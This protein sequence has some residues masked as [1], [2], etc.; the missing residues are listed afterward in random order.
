MKINKKI[1]LSLS[2]GLLFGIVFLSFVSAGCCFDSS[3]GLCTLYADS[4][5]CSTFGGEYF[6]SQTCN[7]N[8]C[9]LGCCQLGQ[10]TEYVTQRQCEIDSSTYGFTTAWSQIGRNECNTLSNTQAEG[11]CV[12]GEYADVCTYT[13]AGECA[14]V[15]HSNTNCIDLGICEATSDN[16]CYK[17]DV[18]Y[19][20]SCGNIANKKEDC[21]YDGGTICTEK[22]YRD[23][24]CRN[25]NCAGGKKN[26][27]SW[28][29]DLFGNG[30]VNV[31][32][33]EQMGWD[34]DRGWSK[35]EPPVGS[36]YFTQTCLDGVII[37]TGCADFRSETC[38]SGENSIGAECKKND[39]NI[40][41]EANSEE[42]DAS[43]GSKVDESA[44]DSEY[45]NIFTTKVEPTAGST[46][47]IAGGEVTVNTGANAGSNEKAVADLHLEMCVPNVKGGLQ[48]YKSATTSSSSSSKESICS[49]GS[50]KAAVTFHR[51]CNIRGT[52]PSLFGATDYCTWYLDTP[53]G[54]YGYAGLL[55]EADKQWG[56]VG[57]TKIWGENENLDLGEGSHEKGEDPYSGRMGA[58][59]AGRMDKTILS[60]ETV[61]ALKQRCAAISDCAV[62]WTWIGKDVGPTNPWGLII[63]SA[64]GPENG[65][66]YM[67]CKKSGD[68]KVTCNFEFKCVP[69][70]AETSDSECEKCGKDGLPCSEYRC[71]TLGSGCKFAQPDGVD[72][73]YCVKESDKSAPSIS[74]KDCP[75]EPVRPWTPITFTI[76]TD[77]PSECRFNFKSAG[78]S[79][80]DMQYEFGT[81]GYAMQHTIKLNLPGQTTGLSGDIS[82]YPLLDNE[83]GKYKLLVRCIDV[84]GNGKTSNPYS[85][86]FEVMQY[87]DRIPPS[88]LSFNPISGSS[89][90]YNTTTKQISFEL[91]EPA[92]CRWSFED[93]YFNQSENNFDC[94]TEINQNALAIYE[95][96]GT[97]RNITTDLSEETK[98]YIKCK[99]QPWLEGNETDLYKRN[100]QDSRTGYE[101]ILRPSEFFE[102][103]EVAPSGDV[104]KGG[105]NITIDLSAITTGGSAGGVSACKW[106]V[107]NS[108]PIIAGWH[109]FIETNSNIHRQVLTSPFIGDNYVQ[110][111]CVDSAGNIDDKNITVNLFIDQDGPIIVRLYNKNNNLKIFTNED[112]M[113]YTPLDLKLGCGFEFENAVLMSGFENEHQTTWK[114]GQ[115]YFIRCKDYQG[116]ENGG[117][118]TIIRTY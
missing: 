81:E 77:K 110:V 18:Y 97:L 16:V 80:D 13:T 115:N 19:K 102:I 64:G 112:S 43:T 7:V 61:K 15:F 53:N 93:K 70:K 66:F 74:C 90:R 73:G 91:N 40:C 41:A 58:I 86:N 54:N 79:Y 33:P 9:T 104:K 76:A 50:Y 36:R 113:C 109:D 22:S 78:G 4:S 82:E 55:N 105:A 1:I 72:K 12:I 108:T 103:F 8:K 31:K 52:V 37:T 67:N 95:C 57:G 68:D 117:C 21:S 38:E 17:E 2:I 63:D 114:N 49:Q 32:T 26:G 30:G 111:K 94:T 5:G 14:G 47:T 65:P 11:A 71:M 25:L 28:C 59:Y 75:K 62:Q 69:F 99:D 84:A 29:V 98:F 60:T 24:Y 51:E 34:I 101:Y 35:S 27:D 107:S 92:E 10:Q 44:C 88:I 118:A 83:G 96:S 45:C 6:S 100:E 42:A 23:A 85:I 116:N 39:W 20:D 48:F 56:G 46:F 106:R 87:P 3:N 89:I